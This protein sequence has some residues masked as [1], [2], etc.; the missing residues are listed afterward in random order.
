MQVE[1]NR[2]VR[3]EEVNNILNYEYISDDETS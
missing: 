3:A 1:G 2:V